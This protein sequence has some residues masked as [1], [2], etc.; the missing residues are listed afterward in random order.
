M[1]KL[2]IPKYQ[3]LPPPLMFDMP[4]LLYYRILGVFGT[5]EGGCVF[6][7][8]GRGVRVRHKMTV[9]HAILMGTRVV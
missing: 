9:M 2:V 8:R 3:T 1:P 4:I 5:R 6:D 7:N